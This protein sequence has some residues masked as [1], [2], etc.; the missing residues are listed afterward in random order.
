[1]NQEAVDVLKEQ[2]EKA[3]ALG[4]SHER[5]LRTIEMRRDA[6]DAGFEYRPSVDSFEVTR[7]DAEAF[8]G[9]LLKVNVEIKP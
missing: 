2:I 8:I 4:R 3:Y 9:E 6:G 5:E 7:A 1:M